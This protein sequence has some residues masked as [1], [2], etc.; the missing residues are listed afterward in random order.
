MKAF[1]KSRHLALT[2]ALAAVLS[3][4]VVSVPVQAQDNAEPEM[5]TAIYGSANGWNANGAWV[6][7]SLGEDLDLTDADANIKVRY[8]YLEDSEIKS[9][10]KTSDQ[11]VYEK[12]KAWDGYLTGTD[13]KKYSAWP[14]ENTTVP[15]GLVLQTN[16][17]QSSVA[18]LDVTEKIKDGTVTQVRTV[19]EVTDEEGVVTTA[20][21]NW[22]TYDRN[23]T[24]S[25]P[26]GIT[27][28]EVVKYVDEHPE[29]RFDAVASIGARQFTTLNAALAAAVDGDT[30]LLKNGHYEGGLTIDQAV[31]IIGESKEGTVIEATDNTKSHI[32]YTTDNV[33]LRNLTID[34]KKNELTA[35]H[36]QGHGIYAVKGLNVYNVDVVNIGCRQQGAVCG[37]QTGIGIY[38]DSPQGAENAEDVTIENVSITEFQ[39]AGIVCKTNGSVRIDGALIKGVGATNATAQNGIQINNTKDATIRNAEISDLW[40][41]GAEVSCGVL[42]VNGANVNVEGSTFVDVENMVSCYDED[43]VAYVNDSD[44][45]TK[46]T[47]DNPDGEVVEILCKGVALDRNELTLAVGDSAELNAILDPENST[48]ELVWTSSDENIAAVEGN[49]TKGVITAKAEGTVTITVTCGDYSASATVKVGIPATELEPSDPITPPAQGDG[50]ETQDPETGSASH[51]MAFVTLALASAACGGVLYVRKKRA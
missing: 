16:L 35:A 26:K 8:E 51:I 31:T 25:T 28:S 7:F 37:C 24:E 38:V 43:A 13:G 19:V 30:I 11:S 45:I 41:N 5:I 1:K 10:K 33:T 47:Y 23:L 42:L 50:N 29:T 18:G 20:K 36:I 22:V 4:S 49:G 21:S 39:K 6:G 34:G 32:L 12:N 40:Y 17:T 27:Y 9:V 48:Q 2:G 15:A 44:T 46:Y 3:M 14:N